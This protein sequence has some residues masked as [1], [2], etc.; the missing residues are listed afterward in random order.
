MRKIAALLKLIG[1]FIY[2]T[3]DL[4]FSSNSNHIHV[5]QTVLVVF[6]MG[7]III[8]YAILFLGIINAMKHFQIG[9]I[10]CIDDNINNNFDVSD[11]YKHYISKTYTEWK[12]NFPQNKKI[13]K[14]EEFRKFLIR[15]GRQFK[16]TYDCTV[17]IMVPFLISF[18]FSFKDIKEID[19]VFKSLGI[20][21][22]LIF[23][24]IMISNDLYSLDN[25]VSFFEDCVEVCD[26]YMK[27]QNK[28]NPLN[29]EDNKD[30][31]ENTLILKQENRKTTVTVTME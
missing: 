16:N 3:A 26:E 6:K 19:G 30:I 18:L 25:H 14:N 20:V 29:V 2:I 31:S 17:A 8:I 1:I 7:L 13:Q 5:N 15:K 22:G 9:S 21:A 10:Y 28:N 4:F 24:I 12:N 11:E 23:I 27:S